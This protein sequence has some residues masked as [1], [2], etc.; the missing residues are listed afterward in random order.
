MKK[1]TLWDIAY[2][3][4][5]TVACW[6]SYTAAAWILASLVV[7]SDDLLGGMWAVVATIFVFRQTRV[8]SLSAGLD[9]LIATVVSFALCFA[10]LLFLPSTPLAIGM[11]I[12]IGTLIMMLLDRRGD[13]ALTGITTAVVLVVAS[14]SPENGWQQPLL[15][16]VDTLV[17]VAVGVS[18]KW[19]ASYVFYRAIGEPVR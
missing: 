4:D 10:Y 19:V 16:L 11:L 1:L 18:C 9:R 7:K 2:V 6:L 8:T 13:I 15:R 14:I 3:I 12:G 17:G 5:V